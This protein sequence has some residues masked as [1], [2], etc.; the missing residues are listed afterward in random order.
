MY[1]KLEQAG[2]SI[3]AKMN[4]LMRRFSSVRPKEERLWKIIEE[5]EMLNGVN[6]ENLKPRK[7]SPK[8]PFLAKATATQLAVISIV[9]LVLSPFG[10]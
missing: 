5:F 7:K 9:C 2:E 4:K 3:H 8:I 10:L 6:F 1:Y